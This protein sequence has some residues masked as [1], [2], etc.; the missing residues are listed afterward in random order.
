VKLPPLRRPASSM[1]KCRRC[2]GLPLR[3]DAAVFARRHLKGNFRLRRRDWLGD[4]A[5]L[6]GIGPIERECHMQKN[7]ALSQT[8]TRSRLSGV[9]TARAFE[10]NEPPALTV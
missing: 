3:P 6:A 4:I 5:G 10:A 1:A 8:R 7:Q 9:A 2:P